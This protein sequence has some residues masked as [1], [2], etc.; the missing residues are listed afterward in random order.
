MPGSLRN[1]LSIKGSAL[2][3]NKCETTNPIIKMIKIARI[4]PNPGIEKPNA[5][6]R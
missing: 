3:L 6:F 5:A 1:Q 4:K 2:L